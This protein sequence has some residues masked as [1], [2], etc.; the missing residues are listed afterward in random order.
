MQKV[1]GIKKKFWFSAHPG[2][3]MLMRTSLARGCSDFLQRFLT[4]FRNSAPRNELFCFKWYF[5]WWWSWVQAWWW[6][7]IIS[8]QGIS[9]MDY[10][11]WGGNYLK[12]KKFKLAALSSFIYSHMTLYMVWFGVESAPLARTC[13]AQKTWTGDWAPQ[14]AKIIYKR[15]NIDRPV[16]Q[17]LSDC[18]TVNM[19]KVRFKPPKFAC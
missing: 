8:R 17:I 5:Y 19:C 6:E 1:L 7:F 11:R 2:G 18:R 3:I 10:V 15:V 4:D 13:G 9:W 16:G 12:M 14:L